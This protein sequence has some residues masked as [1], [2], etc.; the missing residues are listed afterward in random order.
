MCVVVKW[1]NGLPANLE[2][3]TMNYE[4]STQDRIWKTLVIT[5]G[6]TAGVVGMTIMSAGASPP[7]VDDVDRAVGA[8]ERAAAA[9]SAVKTLRLEVAEE[10][11]SEAARQRAEAL[12]ASAMDFGPLSFPSVPDDWQAAGL[13]IDEATRNSR[14]EL[15]Q[16]LPDG[17][18]VTLTI[19][20]DIQNYA[21]SL[22]KNRPVPHGAIVIV[23]PP[24]GRVLAMADH[25]R[26]DD[27]YT[28]LA[29]NAG[30]P[31]ASVFKVVTAAAL[32]EESVLSRHDEVCYHGGTRRL[33]QRNIVG[34]P[35]LDNQCDDL[36]GALARSL[37]SMIAKSTY[38]N[39]SREDL[40]NWAERFGYNQPI[41]FELPLQV[42]RAEFGDDPYEMARAAAGFW[43]THLSPL[44][45]ALIGASIAN[46]GVMMRPTIIDRYESPDGDLLYRSEPEVLREVMS[47]ET[48]RQLDDMMV[49]TTQR[50]SARRHFAHRAAF[51]RQVTVS[52]KT[53]TLSDQNPFLRFTWFVGTARHNQWDDHPGVAIAGLM[54]N[55]Q[56]WHILGPQAASFALQHYFNTESARR[57][58]QDDAVVSR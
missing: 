34:D 3:R 5:G 41:P 36:E 43:H 32:L 33:T 2:V 4:Q 11:S 47:P 28:G 58:N 12:R 57:A 17:S 23:D 50:G 14:G 8:A 24:T 29:T 31:S 53:G 35:N 13:D 25:S 22:I 18:R 45:G 20:P 42:S 54:A 27:D 52:G 38:H 44:H 55:E 48:A 21:E 9:E 15:V 37:N 56:Q 40:E 46:D 26:R 6:L 49:A 39:L 1:R 10:R 7:A 51:P 30:P 19:D 16:T